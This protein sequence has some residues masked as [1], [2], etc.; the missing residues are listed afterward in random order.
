MTKYGQGSE[1]TIPKEG[2]IWTLQAARGNFTYSEISRLPRTQIGRSRFKIGSDTQFAKIRLV[3]THVLENVIDNLRR[4][5]DAGCSQAADRARAELLTWLNQ[6][7]R[8]F[9]SY[10]DEGEWVQTTINAASPYATQ[11][12]LFSIA[13]DKLQLR[14]QTPSSDLPDDLSFPISDAGAFRTAIATKDPVTALR[15][16]GEVSELLSNGHKTERA[17][18]LP[19]TNGDRVSAVLFASDSASDLNALE[20]IAGIA[21]SVLERKANSSLH[22]QISAPSETPKAAFAIDPAPVAK[23][24]DRGLAAWG[25]LPIEE[26]Q[27]HLRAQ[28]FA[29]VSVAE[30]QMA[31]PDACRAGREQND[32]YLFLKREIDKARENYRKQYMTVSSMVDYLHL[33]LLQT[34]AEGNENKLGADYPGRLL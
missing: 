26:R 20:L 6:L 10:Q 11:V 7:V 9:R 5:F 18:L 3:A 15:T 2:F 24:V 23:P 25:D 32:L 21:S 4:E 22:A 12:V 34:A 19:I 27:L 8:R 30:I 33:E 17:H 28:R 31:R 16:Q 1:V 13:N 14:G 29:R